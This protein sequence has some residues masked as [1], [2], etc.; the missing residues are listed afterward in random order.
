MKKAAIATVTALVMALGGYT[1]VSGFDK[2]VQLAIHEADYVAFDTVADIEQHSDLIVQVEF[3]GDRTLKQWDV[4]KASESKV[5][6]NKVYKGSLNKGDVISVYE[7]GYQADD[8]T[9]VSV[10]GYNL[11]SEKGKYVLF[12]RPFTDG[13]Y[14]IV[15]M[16]QGKY[17][18]NTKALAKE[19]EQNATYTDLKHQEYF[20]DR[21]AAFNKLK[22]EVLAKYN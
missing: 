17:D 7:A 4:E 18:L 20:G 19:A 10:E 3:T 14:I 12:L 8:N 5:Q 9:V 6:I 21:T 11:M 2:D 1:T 22:K 16:Y 13:N 15:G